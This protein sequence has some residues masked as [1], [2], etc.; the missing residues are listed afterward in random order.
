ML[1]QSIPLDIGLHYIIAFEFIC[2]LCNLFYITELV[3]N[4]LCNNL[5]PSGSKSPFL[6]KCT[7]NGF[8]K[9]GVGGPN[10]AVIS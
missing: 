4:E 7:E 9:C 2:R 6:R 1:S 8:G 3:S 10:L 5:G